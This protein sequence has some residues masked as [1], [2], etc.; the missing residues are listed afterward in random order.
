[1][2]ELLP[3]LNMGLS[4]MEEIRRQI[5]IIEENEDNINGAKNFEIE[6]QKRVHCAVGQHTTYCYLCNY[7]CH[8]ICYISSSKN[9]RHCASMNNG[10][11]TVCPN[12]CEYIL[13][14]DNEYYYEFIIKNVKK[15][16]EDL[17]SIYVYANKN[18]SAAKQI[19]IGLNKEFNKI[20]FEIQEQ[21][22]KY[23]ERLNQIALKPNVIKSR[24]EYIDI[25]INSEELE[26]KRRI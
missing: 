7:T 4:K 14:N 15:T 23:I 10:I 8:K 19:I 9:K 20:Y 16:L 17:K 13:H 12:K 3:Q 24:E 22:K 2:E 1:M 5:R 6:E 11:C 21:L 18:L 25:L 26:K